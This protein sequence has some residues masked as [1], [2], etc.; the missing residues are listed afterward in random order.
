MAEQVGAR[1]IRPA[2]PVDNT[3]GG[4][5]SPLQSSQDLAE[6]YVIASR[7]RAHTMQKAGM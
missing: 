3:P 4:E 1:G 2:E 5:A 7:V 6:L